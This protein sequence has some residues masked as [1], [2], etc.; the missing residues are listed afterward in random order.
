MKLALEFPCLERVSRETG[1]PADK[2]VRAFRIEKAF[3]ES[4][5]LET[6]TERLNR[7]ARDVY[8]E[9]HSLLGKLSE[10]T[11]ATSEH[12]I[13]TFR[14]ELEGKSVLDLGCGEGALLRKLAEMLPH[15]ELVG[16]DFVGAGLPA[17]DAAVRFVADDIVEFD[18]GAKF[19]VVVSDN[20]L[21]HIAPRRLDA[22]IAS[23]RRHLADGGLFLVITPNRLFGPTDM[24]RIVDNT[25]TNRVPAQCAHLNEMT[26][27]ELIAVL[28]RHGFRHFRTMLPKGR[29]RFPH[30]RI[31]PIIPV[32]IERCRPLLWLFYAIQRRTGRLLAFDIVIIARP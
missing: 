6:D 9:L 19:D 22:H 24:T 26:C 23:V 4:A 8:G 30:V 10:S 13:E 5:L 7:M 29:R 11:E 21:E 2:L 15:K 16:V 25:R 20:V 3:H 1:V 31:S 12:R 28:R 17:S 18:A 14:P 27:G 32:A